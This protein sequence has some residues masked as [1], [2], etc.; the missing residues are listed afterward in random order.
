M[1]PASAVLLNSMGY[2]VRLG[3]EIGK[4]GEGA[5]YEAQQF[6]VAAV[7]SCLVACLVEYGKDGR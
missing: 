3:R 2:N 7:E 5:V 4:G 1:S 6:G